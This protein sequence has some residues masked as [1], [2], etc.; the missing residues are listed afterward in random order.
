MYFIYTII[1]IL[2]LFIL[3][4]LWAEEK[5]IRK[6]IIHGKIDNLWMLRERRK[7]VRFNEDLKV[8]YN[9]VHKSSNFFSSKATNISQGGLCLVSYE[10]LK[11]KTYIDLEIDIPSSPK[12]IK[13][14]AQVVW[15]KDLEKQDAQ[16]RRLFYVGLKIS[17][18]NPEYEKLLLAHLNTLKDAIKV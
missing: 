15:N 1:L 6:T 2:L 5:T 14:I 13:V 8:R 11:E 3:K 9:S 10:K 12:P 7:F 4:F 18:I 17:K 16:G